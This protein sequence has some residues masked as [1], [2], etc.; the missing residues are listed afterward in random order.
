[1]VCVCDQPC[2]LCILPLRCSSEAEKPHWMRSY[3]PG[4]GWHQ[5]VLMPAMVRR[6]HTT[7]DPVPSRTAATKRDAAGL[8]LNFRWKEATTFRTETHRRQWFKS[9]PSC[10]GEQ[11]SPCTLL[12]VTSSHLTHQA[13]AFKIK[14]PSLTGSQGSAPRALRSPGSELGAE[15][16]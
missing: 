3:T 7:E 2:S 12:S 10:E 15:A 13:P 5:Q 14:V 9:S 1:M 8:G 16:G 4:M 6:G 11:S